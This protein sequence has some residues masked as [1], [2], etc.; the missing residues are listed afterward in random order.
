MDRFLEIVDQISS[1]IEINE[2]KFNELL[3]KVLIW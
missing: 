1:S 2:T 3:A